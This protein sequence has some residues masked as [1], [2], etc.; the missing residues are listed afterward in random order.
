MPRTIHVR[1]VP[2]FGLVFHVRYRY[3]DPARFLFRRIIDLLKRPKIRKSLHPQRF[4]HRRRQC[5]F[6]VVNVPYRPDVNMRFVSYK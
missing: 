3:R 6:P 4:G 2:I 1:I 5:R